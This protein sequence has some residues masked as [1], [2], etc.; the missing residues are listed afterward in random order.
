MATLKIKK[1]FWKFANTFLLLLRT[2]A[3]KQI[4]NTLK[5]YFLGPKNV[6]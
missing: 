3:K 5:N 1:I 4:C 2:I 6:P